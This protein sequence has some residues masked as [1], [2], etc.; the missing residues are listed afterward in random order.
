[1]SHNV[2]ILAGVLVL[3]M[4]GTNQAQVTFNGPEGV[5]FDTLY[6]R[7]LIAN[8]N[9]QNIVQID[10]YGD[11]SYF[12]KNTPRIGGLRI[13]G[14]LLYGAGQN[15]IV[16]YDLATKTQVINVPIPDASLLNALVTDTSGYLYVSDG[17]PNRIY[18]MKLS[19]QSWSVFVDNDPMLPFPIGLFFEPETN[20]LLVTARPDTRASIRA[21]SLPDGVVSDV[22]TTATYPWFAYITRD[23]AGRYLMSCFSAGIVVRYD[24]AF[25]GP[26]EVLLVH[27]VAP[28]QLFYNTLVDTL[29]VPDYSA[30]TVDFVSFRDDDLDG[31][32]EFRDNCPQLTNADQADADTDGL[33][34]LCDD[35][36]DTDFDGFG[37]PGFPA[38]TC[39]IDHCPGLY[40]VTNQDTDGDGIGNDCDNCPDVANPGQEDEDHNLIGDACEGCCS[41]RVGDANGSGEDEPTIGDVSTMI[42]AKFLTGTCDGILNCLPEADINQSGGTDPVCDDITISDISTLIDYLFITGQSLGLPGCF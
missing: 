34:D 7:Y 8:W 26:S 42:D 35:C 13:V 31:V 1:M 24:H 37:D 9:A 3:I 40:T 39:E 36:T 6:D 38:S 23:N 14:P 21:V 33:G 41:A 18:R 19:D 30:S 28:V 16:A 32:E 15:Q 12:A 2:L 22:L 25:A 17:T 10:E 27:Y 20:R 29:V 5:V 4:A 11:S